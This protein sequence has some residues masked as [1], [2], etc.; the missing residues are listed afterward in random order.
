MA[1][2]FRPLTKHVRLIHMKNAGTITNVYKGMTDIVHR[3]FRERW[4]AVDDIPV[5]KALASGEG[6]F[7][8]TAL[9]QYLND[10]GLT[11]Y[12]H[13]P[14]V[15]APDVLIVGRDGYDMEAIKALLDER[16]GEVLRICSQ[17][18]IL[19][20]SLTGVDP[21]T[22]A[23][24]TRSFIEGHP[25]LEAIAMYLDN[26][27]PGTEPLPRKGTGE[28]VFDIPEKGPLKRLRYKVGMNGASIRVR[29]RA[30]RRAFELPAEDL[31]GTY[32]STYLSE[33]GTRKSSQ[34]LQ[35]MANS[36]AYN[37]Q[38]AYNKPSDMSVAIEHWERDLAWLKKEFYNPLTFSFTWPQSRDS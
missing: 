35:K 24:T 33:W 31:P 3:G 36:I 38:S 8:K 7:E 22:C 28:G 16:R 37:C 4:G 10:R 25:A 15:K 6:P 26:D 27:W 30:L 29:R 9:W 12:Y 20:W 18:M 2:T 21:N 5:D 1:S 13:F 34:R 17:E 11:T 14:K 19:A 23:E 32:T